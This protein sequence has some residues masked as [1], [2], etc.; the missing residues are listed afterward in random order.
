MSGV[1]FIKPWQVMDNI[2]EWIF[3]QFTFNILWVTLTQKI[4]SHRVSK[5][6]K[7]MWGNMYEWGKV[8]LTMTSDR[9]NYWVNFMQFTFN[10]LRVTLTEKI[11]TCRVLIT[12]EWFQGDVY[13]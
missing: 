1:K 3:M 5:I 6:Y 9:S 11:I 12:H 13:E 2:I 4:I 8:S 7:W 10:I